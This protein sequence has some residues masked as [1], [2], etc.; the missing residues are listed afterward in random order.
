[1]NSYK[2]IFIFTRCYWTYINFRKDLVN[3]ISVNSNYKITV[4]MDLSN[5]PKKARLLVKKNL[6]FI[7]FPFINKK[8]SF[9][10]D[11]KNIYSLISIFK[12]SKPDLVHNFTARP[13]IFSLIALKFIKK[14]VL[15]NT[16]TGLGTNFLTTRVIKK[17]FLKILYKFSISESSFIIFQNKDDKFFFK[18]NN[19]I[20]LNT[21]SKI[22]FPLINSK[23]K[24]KKKIKLRKNKK[25]V[26]LMFCRL[27]FEKGIN[28]YFQA[29]KQIKNIF[30]DKVEFYLIGNLDLNNPSSITKIELA[31]WK[32]LNIIKIL[33]HKKEINKYIL[34]SDVIVFPSYGEGLPS[35]LLEASYFGK[36]IITTNVNGCREMVKNKYNGFLIKPRSTIML[37]NR[38]EYLINNRILINKFGLNSKKLFNKKFNKNTL[39]NY[40]ELY[41]KLI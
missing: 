8:K 27:L 19:L 4:F 2:K 3:Y 24:I 29:A 16:V 39:N 30:K 6:S 1:M 20:N 34:K 17:F 25:I 26:F 31:Q 14:K 21:K 41:K 32:K 35:A 36:A 7:N 10:H 38:I 37:K 33:E 15:V 40:L 11:L 18:K 22:I 23:Y 13:V 12:K 9:F 5:K 28:E